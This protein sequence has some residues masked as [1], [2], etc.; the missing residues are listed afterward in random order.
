MPLQWFAGTLR[1]I[2][3][4]NDQA[5]NWGGLPPAGHNKPDHRQNKQQRDH[6]GNANFQRTQGCNSPI[7][8]EHTARCWHEAYERRRKLSGAINHPQDGL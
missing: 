5:I 7:M 3:A 4:C 1:P 2:S 8:Q 6:N